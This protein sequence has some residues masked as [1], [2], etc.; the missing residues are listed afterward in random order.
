MKNLLRALLFILSLSAS[1]A[2][3]GR[4][5]LNDVDQNVLNTDLLSSR[6]N[7]IKGTPYLFEDFSQGI[8]FF[9][10]GQNVGNQAI[11]FDAFAKTVQVNLDDVV[12]YN[13]IYVDSVL[14]SGIED[15]LF[16]VKNV[17]GEFFLLERLLQGDVGFYST[18]KI[19]RKISQTSQTGYDQDAQLQK[20]EQEK[21]HYLEIDKK[22]IE[23]K[24]NKKCILSVLNLDAKSESYLETSKNK[25]RKEEEV[26]EFLKIYNEISQS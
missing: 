6:Y 15:R 13:L 21:V 1:F 8:I 22:L 7:Q 25:L 18:V 2:Q 4:F 9:K 3:N 20:F 24:L 12:E 26:I 16:V 23:C 10:N 5:I 19:Q 17:N 11:R 14:I